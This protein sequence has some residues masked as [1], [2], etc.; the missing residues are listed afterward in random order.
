[1]KRGSLLPAATWLAALLA[2]IALAAA[3]WF[4]FG[5]A[6]AAFVEKP[7][8]HAREEALDAAQGAAL[9]ISTF[10]LADLDASFRNIESSVT[11]KLKDEYVAN[12]E[13]LKTAIT[14]NQ[15]SLGVK[16]ITN[17]SLIELNSDEET[18]K[19]LVVLHQSTTRAN[20]PALLDRVTMTIQLETVDGVWK[21]SEATRLE[22]LP[23]DVPAT[24]Q[25][26]PTPTPEPQPTEPGGR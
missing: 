2:L 9:N 17:V 7:R 10:D 1:M 26:T 6:H 14:A 11:G 18:A 25:P 13:A 15:A 22:T 5:W 3:G 23:L 4:G 20:Q 21:A 19:A 12:K 24:P 8:A 16:E